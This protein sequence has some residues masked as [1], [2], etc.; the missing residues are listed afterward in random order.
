MGYEA[1][2]PQADPLL[3]HPGAVLRTQPGSPR[4]ASS[5]QFCTFAWRL[6]PSKSTC[7]TFAPHC[8][9]PPSVWCS[10]HPTFSGLTRCSW[11]KQMFDWHT[12]S[13]HHCRE[14]CVQRGPWGAK[15]IPL[16][17]DTVRLGWWSGGWSLPSV[18]LPTFQ[19]CLRVS[20]A[21]Q[22]TLACLLCA[23]GSLRQPSSSLMRAT[24]W[25]RW[26]LAVGRVG[27]P[28]EQ[29]VASGTG[30]SLSL[31]GIVSGLYH[32]VCVSHSVMS[33]SLRPHE[34]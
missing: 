22:E 7:W 20:R 18:F 15:L 9:F 21:W 23:R 2:G 24:R 3:G 11:I 31:S 8:S 29:Q 10:A 12:C 19:G 14:P 30:T 5:Q 1:G 26:R 34:L 17:T 6:L 28:S 33:G 27:C 13:S 16:R 25:E 32:C 4:A